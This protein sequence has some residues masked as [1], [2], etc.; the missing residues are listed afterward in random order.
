MSLK[1]R[2][3]HYNQSN[4]VSW[5][6]VFPDS[7]QKLFYYARTLTQTSST[8]RSATTTS[9]TRTS[10]TTRVDCQFSDWSS[11]GKCNRPCNGGNQTRTRSVAVPEVNGGT[12]C[13]GEE[14]E[15]LECNTQT[16]A[17]CV[18]GWCEG[19]KFSKRRGWEELLDDIG[20]NMM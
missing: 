6:Q 11:W 20:C 13:V 1:G 12:P 16:C 2:A 18:P 7:P 4:R 3:D 10:T 9:A 14:E 19:K 5:Q 8:T 17:Q 15:M